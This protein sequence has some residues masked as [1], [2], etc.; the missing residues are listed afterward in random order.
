MKKL[1]IKGLA[2]TK[3]LYGKL[4]NFYQWD[5]SNFCLS[6]VFEYRFFLKVTA[7]MTWGIGGTSNEELKPGILGQMDLGLSHGEVKEKLVRSG[8]SRGL[9]EER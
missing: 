9:K 5:A 2:Y 6:W 1:A 4:S 3:I 7:V 8:I